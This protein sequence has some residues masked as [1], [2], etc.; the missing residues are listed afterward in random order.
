AGIEED[1]LAAVL[2]ERREAPVLLHLRRLAERVVEDGDLLSRRVLRGG[3]RRRRRRTAHDEQK[4]CEVGTHQWLL[5]MYAQER[6]RSPPR[7]GAGAPRGALRVEHVLRFRI[8]VH[9]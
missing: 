8:E 3:R 6:E 7:V 1:S 2:D 4:H 5:S 9:L